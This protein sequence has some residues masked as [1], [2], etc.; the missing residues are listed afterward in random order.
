MGQGK[1]IEIY[2][3]DLSES[4][5]EEVLNELGDDGNYD[6]FPIATIEV[7]PDGCPFV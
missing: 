5:K 2:L 4:K 7:E 6:V 1:V 3:D